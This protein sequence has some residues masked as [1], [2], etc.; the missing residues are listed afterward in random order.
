MYSYILICPY[1]K[2]RRII[3]TLCKPRLSILTIRFTYLDVYITYVSA[4]STNINSAGFL[5]ICYIV[6]SILYITL[7]KRPWYDPE[8]LRYF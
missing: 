6:G 8:N 2:F 7:F 4:G 3:V 5:Y 1:L